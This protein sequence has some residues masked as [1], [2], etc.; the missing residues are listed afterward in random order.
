MIGIILT[1]TGDFAISNN[2]IIVEEADGQTIENILKAN[3]GEFK[4]APLIGG[5]VVKLHNGLVSGLWCANVKKQIES[6][7]VSI[8]SITM[9]SNEIIVKQW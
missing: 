7:G 4:C 8:R 6:V 3:R 1:D 5:E 9:N 2:S